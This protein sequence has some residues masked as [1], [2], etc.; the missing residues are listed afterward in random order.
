MWSLPHWSVI[1]SVGIDRLSS[2]VASVGGQ[3]SSEQS[4]LIAP[5][6]DPRHQALG[7]SHPPHLHEVHIFCRAPR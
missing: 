6:L 4:R 3:W 7:G 1:S 5:R 2:V